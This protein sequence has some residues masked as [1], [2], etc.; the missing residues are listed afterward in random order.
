MSD[1]SA[2]ASAIAREQNLTPASEKHL[3]DFLDRIVFDATEA[4]KNPAVKTA[5][6][7]AAASIGQ[8]LSSILDGHKGGGGGG[9]RRNQ[10]LA[11]EAYHQLPDDNTGRPIKIV[12]DD[13]QA[14][15]Q[16]AK[17]VKNNSNGQQMKPEITRVFLT[18]GV[19]F[20]ILASYEQVAALIG[21]PTK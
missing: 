9:G 21:Q 12:V 1:A 3:R 6:E 18:S 11:L 20:D 4:V 17:E 5:M 16:V 15:T 13:I 8:R 14:C 10:Q 7:Q 2:T 19:S